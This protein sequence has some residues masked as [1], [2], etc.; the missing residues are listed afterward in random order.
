MHILR[1]ELG[2]AF[3]PRGGQAND[4][5]SIHRAVYRPRFAKRSLAASGDLA[6]H[7]VGFESPGGRALQ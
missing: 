4:P 1:G 7:L 5:L 3:D 6:S 2:S